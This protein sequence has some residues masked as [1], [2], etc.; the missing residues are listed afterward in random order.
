[1]NNIW[2]DSV[3]AQTCPV[4]ETFGSEYIF[5]REIVYYVIKLWNNIHKHLYKAPLRPYSSD[6]GLH[7]YALKT[8]KGHRNQICCCF[9]PPPDYFLAFRQW[10]SSLLPKCPR[11]LHNSGANM[12][13]CRY[14]TQA[15]ALEF[16]KCRESMILFDRWLP[17]LWLGRLVASAL[18]LLNFQVLR[19]RRVLWRW[20]PMSLVVL[21]RAWRDPM[22]HAG[23]AWYSISS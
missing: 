14:V 22:V 21:R 12:V 3:V 11:H 17:I 13:I 15:Q 20:K 5:I 23:I 8:T 19:N 16:S 4:L 6:Y 9:P 7:D 2:S 10:S 18:Q 1:M